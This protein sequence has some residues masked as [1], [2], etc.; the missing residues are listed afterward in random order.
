MPA[1][2][3]IYGMQSLITL[4]RAGVWM[5]YCYCMTEVWGVS[6]PPP[7]LSLPASCAWHAIRLER[8]FSGRGGGVARNGHE[9]SRL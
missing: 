6:P 7:Q 1:L 4:H 9:R 3:N 5:H 8:R 2:I